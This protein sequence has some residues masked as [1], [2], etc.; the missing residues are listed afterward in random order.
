ILVTT[1][2]LLASSTVFVDEIVRAQPLDHELTDDLIVGAMLAATAAFAAITVL[3]LRDQRKDLTRGR[4]ITEAARSIT[5]TG[6]TAAIVHGLA[7]QA[8]EILRAE[9]AFVF[10]REERDPGIGEVVAGR[11]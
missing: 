8:A 10:L 5:V 2:V 7:R 3:R 4:A 11:G 6:H 9:T 1:L